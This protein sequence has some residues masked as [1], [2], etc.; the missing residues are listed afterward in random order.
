M[1][2]SRVYTQKLDS[3]MYDV[4]CVEFYTNHS[5]EFVETTRFMVVNY[6]IKH[7]TNLGFLTPKEIFPF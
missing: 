4:V 5:I 2:C 6:R 7:K 1:T 3:Y